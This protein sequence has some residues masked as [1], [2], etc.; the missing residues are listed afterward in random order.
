MYWVDGWMCGWV[1][2]ICEQQF[3]NLACLAYHLCAQVF[4]MSY[5]AGDKVTT[6]YDPK[7]E[8]RVHGVK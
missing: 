5:D 8:P 7:V 6:G 3:T 4:V 2:W 1:E